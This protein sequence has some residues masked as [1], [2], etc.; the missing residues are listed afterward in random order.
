MN[1]KDVELTK[2][3]VKI[4]KNVTRC[5]I[6]DKSSSTQNLP[7]WDSLAYMAIL[8]E[9]EVSYGIFITEENINSFDSVESIVEIIINKTE[10]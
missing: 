7:Q 6:V 9:I 3:V 5:A 8:S 1:H 2:D 4:V 10:K